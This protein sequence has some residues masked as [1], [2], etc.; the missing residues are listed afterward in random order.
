VKIICTPYDRLRGGTQGYDSIPRPNQSPD[1]T[2]SWFHSSMLMPSDNYTGS[3]IAVFRKPYAPTDLSYS[4]GTLRWTPNTLSYEAKGY[5]VYKKNGGNWELITPTPVSGTSLA[6]GPGQY[7]VTMQEWSG[8]ES[9][10]SS[11]VLDTVSG[12]KTAA[13]TGWD[14][15]APP[16]VTGL[17]VT[18]EL[19]AQGQYRL[20]W[21]TDTATDLRYYNIYFSSLGRPAISQ[22]RLVVS[23]AADQTEYLDWTAPIDAPGYYWAITAI[24]RQ[25]NESAPTF[26]TVP[27]PA[28][29]T[30]LLAGAIGMLRTCRKRDKQ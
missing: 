27:E 15:V 4:N 17:T 2:K 29:L 25:G 1:A 7:M 14:K 6:T 18:P 26:V 16:P 28:T 20:K 3:Y 19:D 9:D 21:N 8:L 13:I 11:V 10:T 12:I 24:D 30:L 5:L 22:Q 23:P